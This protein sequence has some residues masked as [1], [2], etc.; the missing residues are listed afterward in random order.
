ML[1][2]REHSV[3]ELNRKLKADA[4]AADADATDDVAMVKRLLAELIEQG[5]QSDLRFTE[6]LCRSRYG[7]GRGP[8]KLRHELAEH[9]IATPL[10]EQV[11]AGYDGKWGAL[12]N[13]TRRKKFGAQPPTCYREWAKQARFL[14]QRG[15]AA[16][17]IERFD[18]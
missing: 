5:A 13:E 6:Q 1:A 4:A 7:R 8:V 16:E 12:A 15:F 18:G 2:R 9:H 3:W 11:M 10:V 17:Q 14:E